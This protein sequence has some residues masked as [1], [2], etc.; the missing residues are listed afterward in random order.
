M[1]VTKIIVEKLEQ[2]HKVAEDIYYKIA[3]WTTADQV[4]C[5]DGKNVQ[6]KIGNIDGI[7]D[8]YSSASSKYAVSQKCIEGLNHFVTGTL[9]AGDTILTLKD[10]NIKTSSMFDIYNSIYGVS[11]TAVVA[12]NGTLRLTYPE[13]TQD[14]EVKVRILNI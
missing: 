14:L 4:T 3:P 10:S 7:S 13:M 5:T 9:S 1:G 2:Y 6:S 12:T 8:T 11:A